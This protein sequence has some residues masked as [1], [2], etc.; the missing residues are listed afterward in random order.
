MPIISQSTPITQSIPASVRIFLKLDT[1]A[2]P[3]QYPKFPT[4]HYPDRVDFPDWTISRLDTFPTGHIPD[5]TLSRLDNFPT[6]HYPDW[7]HSRLNYFPI[8]HF[9]F[10]VIGSTFSVGIVSSREIVQ[11]EM[12]PV[13]NLGYCP[14]F[15]M[16]N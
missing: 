2:L 9:Q 14:F 16:Q 1:Y 10:F 7:T 13:G 12:C 6:G 8:G 5:R 11:S 3:R 4:G 15:G